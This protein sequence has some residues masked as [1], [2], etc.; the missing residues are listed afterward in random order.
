MKLIKTTTSV[1]MTLLVAATSVFAVEEVPDAR[2]FAELSRQIWRNS[3]ELT[4]TVGQ[5]NKNEQDHETLRQT[6]LNDYK[7]VVENYNKA[8]RNYTE[9]KTEE[10]R[11]ALD[12]AKDTETE[13]RSELT[14]MVTDRVLR[15]IEH[16]DDVTQ[17]F[18]VLSKSYE[19]LGNVA[20]SYKDS[21]KG[22]NSAGLNY[23]VKSSIVN[24][25]RIIKSLIAS[26]PENEEL[27]DALKTVENEAK[28]YMELGDEFTVDTQI[29]KQAEIL[30]DLTAQLGR[31]KLILE[32]RKKEITI[33]AV[34]SLIE[35]ALSG[36]D[37]EDA[38]IPTEILNDAKKVGTDIE[39]IRKIQ[40]QKN[41]MKK[42]S[43]AKN[44]NPASYLDQLESEL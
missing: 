20:S 31:V 3:S 36:I 33:F 5:F 39:D 27:K 17:R 37:F 15:S 38:I 29:K 26:D 32:R 6:K 11:L 1:A 41:S 25:G 35:D 22:M 23:Q 12:K 30:K 44:S 43:K 13:V 8:L 40:L 28:L 16:I 42:P 9:K 18:F 14:N 4:A 10:N 24:S 7:D 19:E 34:T 2:Q 21:L